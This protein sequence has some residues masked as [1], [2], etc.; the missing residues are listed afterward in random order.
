[1][2]TYKKQLFL[3]RNGEKFTHQGET[4]TM[5]Q[6]EGNMAEVFKNGQFYAWPTWNGKSS[7]VVDY[8]SIH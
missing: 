6:I 4:Y 5:F 8:I 3:L 1:M 7:I 2:T